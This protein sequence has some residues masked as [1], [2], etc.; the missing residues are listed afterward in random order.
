MR[1]KSILLAAALLLAGGAARAQQAP[2]SL[3]DCIDYALEHNLS[4]QQSSLTVVASTMPW[5][6]T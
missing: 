2:W 3:A 5:S 6:T 4:V 1:T